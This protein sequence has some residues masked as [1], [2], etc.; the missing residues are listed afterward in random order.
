M[1]KLIQCKQSWCYPPPPPQ[2]KK[3]KKKEYVSIFEVRVLL[4]LTRS[5]SEPYFDYQSF[6]AP[7]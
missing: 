3:K 7:A 5:V 4:D 2:K 1:L 6:I